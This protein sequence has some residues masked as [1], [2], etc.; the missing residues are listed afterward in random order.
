MTKSKVLITSLFASTAI[1]AIGW[2]QQQAAASPP[3]M[4][5]SMYVEYFADSGL[6]ALVVEA[7]ADAD[8]A[9]GTVGIRDPSGAPFLRVL[10]LPG[11]HLGLSGYKLE[12]RLSTLAAVLAD[13]APGNYRMSVHMR[14]G[15]NLQGTSGLSHILPAAPIIGYPSDGDTA[16]PAKE[17]T[18]TWA[19]VPGAVGYRIGLEQGDTDTLL[20]RLPASASSFRV[21]P[22][23]LEPGVPTGLEVIAVGA[24]GNRTV[25]ERTFTTR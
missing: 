14:E 6:A 21:P 12:S 25:S 2:T 17:L 9:V 13:S 11:Q 7:E 4:H 10:S 24:N 20:A 18:I 3:Q 8:S 16:V 5:Q 19:L 22:G 1:G 23:M 15:S